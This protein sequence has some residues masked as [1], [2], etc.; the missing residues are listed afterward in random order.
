M[1]KLKVKIA[2]LKKNFLK[3]ILEVRSKEASDSIDVNR[4]SLMN[5]LYID[6]LSKSGKCPNFSLEKRDRP[7][8]KGFFKKNGLKSRIL[9]I[10]GGI[11]FKKA[12][13]SS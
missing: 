10:L 4:T 6:F 7:K 12:G 2:L 5:M 3:E 13:F 1:K 8:F 9:R 11:T